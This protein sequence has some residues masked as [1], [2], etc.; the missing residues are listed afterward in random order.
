MDL[1]HNVI[2][3]AKLSFAFFYFLAIIQLQI[4]CSTFSSPHLIC[5]E[6]LCLKVRVTKKGRDIERSA[7]HWLTLQMGT[8]ARMEQAEGRGQGASCKSPTRIAEASVLGAFSAFPRLLVRNWTRSR[9][10][11]AGT[12]AH[13]GCRHRRHQLY[14]LGDSATPVISC[15]SSALKLFYQMKQF[16]LDCP[17]TQSPTT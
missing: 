1:R 8:T 15:I 16:K 3:S 9:P 5:K 13:M 6:F 14:S 11:G 4:F 2:Q 17:V 7:I 10:A 12:G